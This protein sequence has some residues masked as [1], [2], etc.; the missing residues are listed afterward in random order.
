MLSHCVI[1]DFYF[2]VIESV[3]LHRSLL[4]VP[5]TFMSFLPLLQLVLVVGF[6]EMGTLAKIQ[7]FIGKELTD[8]RR[9][10]NGPGVPSE[11]RAY[12][13]RNRIR[14]VEGKCHGSAACWWARLFTNLR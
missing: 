7:K 8:M 4:A 14:L 5:N 12:A 6:G 10:E 13:L 3:V 1:D 9:V 11:T 2:Y